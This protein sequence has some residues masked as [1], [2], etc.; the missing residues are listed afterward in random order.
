MGGGIGG[1]AVKG[2]AVLPFG[3]GAGGSTVHK[4]RVDAT[5]RNVRSFDISLF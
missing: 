3:G 2:G 1:K 4:R 5:R